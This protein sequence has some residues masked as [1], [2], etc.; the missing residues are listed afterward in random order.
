MV[1]VIVGIDNG[2]YRFIG[3]LVELGLDQACR[4]LGLGGI[5]DDDAVVA[6]IM[7]LLASA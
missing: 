3:N 4:T 7:M 1:G 2:F 6:T 5:D